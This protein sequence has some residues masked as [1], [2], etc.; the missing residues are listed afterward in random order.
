MANFDKIQAKRNAALRARQLAREFTSDV[1]R[2]RALG[3]AADLEAEADHLAQ[4]RPRATVTQM[5]MQV[6]QGAPL[7]NGDK[8]K[9]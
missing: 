8:D 7:A 1:D 2:A 9:R 3:F 5:Q 6:Q 4:E